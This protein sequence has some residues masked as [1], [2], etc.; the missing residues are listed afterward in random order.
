MPEDPQTSLACVGG[1]TV[2][3]LAATVD[4]I[5]EVQG[6]PVAA[7]MSYESANVAEL[8]KQLATLTANASAL[9]AAVNILLSRE[10]SRRS[11]YGR[12]SGHSSRSA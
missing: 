1:N 11:R 9:T 2:E 12:P 5:L 7:E 4:K 6:H 3:V 8:R 10:Q